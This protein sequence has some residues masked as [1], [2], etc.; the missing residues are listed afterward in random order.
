[1]SGHSPGL[2]RS[3]WFWL[4]VFAL[5]IA[6]LAFTHEIG[7]DE[8]QAWNIA[9]SASWPWDVIE[10][11]RY[12]GHT[13]FWHGVLWLLSRP[14]D[15]RLMQAFSAVLAVL[16]AALLL[17]DRPFPQR[18]CVLIL[19]S[20]LMLY[21]YAV[22][23][24][25]YSLALLLSCLLASLLRRGTASPFTLSLLCA[26]LAFTSAFGAVISL[27]LMSV[28]LFGGTARASRPMAATAIAGS[29]LYAALLA[30]SIW[31]VVFPIGTNEFESEMISGGKAEIEALPAPIITA[32]FPHLD[33]LPL[34][35]GDWLSASGNGHV[36]AIGAA[37]LVVAAVG[38]LLAAR[39]A[40][41]T[42][43]LVGAVLF[44]LAATF[45]GSASERHMGNLFLLALVLCW[46]V[47]GT[48]AHHVQGAKAAHRVAA[49]VL[50][51]VLCYQVLIGLASAAYDLTR[52]QSPWQTIAETI[53]ATVDAPY[54]LYID[55]GYIGGAVTAYL[56]IVPFDMSCPCFERH[57]SWNAFVGTPFPR[58]VVPMI[59]AHRTPGTR[60]LLLITRV[61]WQPDEHFALI[62]E[63]DPG[64]REANKPSP[65]LYR[66]E[67]GASTDALCGDTLQG[68]AATALRRSS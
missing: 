41:L 61:D 37:L 26:L 22:I 13:A 23:P 43:W 24:R 67:E 57:R 4:C 68:S 11:G 5:A 1:M 8:A 47:R 7:H 17:R 44:T 38:L 35:I 9:R 56:D 21:E 48:P 12:E 49:T 46:S 30:A 2:E 62:G 28:I 42:A 36:L 64:Y 20:Y 59:C 45:S 58:Q 29:A 27:P 18:V 52:E 25:P 6:T 16:S 14:G 65:R 31:L 51:G 15:P 66:L 32:S 34:G 53:D 39:P 55:D 33:R 19:F 63:F 3:D 10:T 40:A 60:P 54:T 50:C